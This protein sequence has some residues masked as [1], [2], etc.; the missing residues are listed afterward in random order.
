MSIALRMIET[1][2]DLLD[3]VLQMR[4]AERKDGRKALSRKVVNEEGE[5]RILI[6]RW[7]MDVKL[8]SFGKEIK[9]VKYALSEGMVL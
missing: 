8:N 9:Y 7:R 1:M 2:M 5:W 6:K 3:L 4:Y